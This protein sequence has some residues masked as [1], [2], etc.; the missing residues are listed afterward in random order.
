MRALVFLLVAVLAACGSEPVRPPASAPARLPQSLLSHAFDVPDAIPPA[1]LA[2][3]TAAMERELDQALVGQNLLRRDGRGADGAP[4][5][6][7][8]AGGFEVSSAQLRAAA[9]APLARCAAVLHAY[10]AIVV[11]VRGNGDDERALGARRA[12]AVAAYLDESG[13]SSSRLRTTWSRTIAADR[14]ELSI[15]PIVIG[16]EAQ[17]WM[18]PR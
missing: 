15:E 18:P 2:A 8:T 14:V 11:Q 6:M 16:H 12:V 4:R 13:V 3:L 17:A 10:G 5:L 9:L 7:L 1:Q